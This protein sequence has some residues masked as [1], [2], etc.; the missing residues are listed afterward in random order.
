M[1]LEP[2]EIEAVR[3]ILEY[4]TDEQLDYDELLEATGRTPVNHVWGHCLSLQSALKRYE[5]GDS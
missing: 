3:A 5:E 4:L 1:L 2:S